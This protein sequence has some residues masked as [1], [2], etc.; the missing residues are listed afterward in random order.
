MFCFLLLQRAY[1][2]IGYR[3][4]VIAALV[5]IIIVGHKGPFV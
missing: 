1:D 2:S 5:A 4:V 3:V